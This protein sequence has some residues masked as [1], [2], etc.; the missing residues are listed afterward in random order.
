MREITAR[1]YHLC[2]NIKPGILISHPWFERFVRAGY[3]INGAADGC[4]EG[5]APLIEYYWGNDAGLFDFLN[6]RAYAAWK[7]LLQDIFI[8]AGAEGIWNDNNEYEI[9]D[10]YLPAAWTRTLQPLLMARAACEALRERYPGRRPWVISRSGYAGLQRYA[11][12]WSGDNVSDFQSLSYNI[13]MGLT[14]NLSGM[15]FVGHDIGGFYGAFPSREL[16]IRW[17]QSAALQPRCVIN[18]WNDNGRPTE[19]WSYPEE[20]ATIREILHTR[21]ELMP[22]LYSAAIAARL[23]GSGVATPAMSRVRRRRSARRRLPPP[24]GGRCVAGGEC[25]SRRTRGDRSASAARCRLVRP[26]TPVGLPRRR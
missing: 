25:G 4:G 26:P 17:F 22:Y 9:E 10:P 21:Y 12:T 15:F 6:P 2:F 18:S 13:L 11:R 14:L 19:P 1:G 24:S 3:L 16:L 23:L 8:D 7:A 5:Y 20:I